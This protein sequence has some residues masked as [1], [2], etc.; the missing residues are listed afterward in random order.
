VERCSKDVPHKKLEPEL[1]PLERL[2]MV[3]SQNKDP[4][5]LP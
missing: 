1:D 4:I 3:A 5:Q 2:L